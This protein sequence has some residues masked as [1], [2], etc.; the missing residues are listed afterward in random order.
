MLLV[1]GWQRVR[2]LNQQICSS[3]LG[4]SMQLQQLKTTVNRDFADVHLLLCLLFCVVSCR[5]H[6]PGEQLSRASGAKAVLVKAL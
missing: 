4:Y 2:Q 3:M 1:F 6:G 5:C